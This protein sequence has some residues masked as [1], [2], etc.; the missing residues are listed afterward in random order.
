MNIVNKLTLRQL[1]MNKKRTL[2]T[3]IGTIISA[4]MIT[5]VATLS[6]S[7]MD[8][9]Q[10]D[11]IQSDG[12]W[13]AKY[14]EVTAKQ[15]STIRKDKQVKTVILS[16]DL[17][18]SYL[19][20]SR[21]N[22]KPYLSVLEYNKAGYENFPI[23]LT[24]G[25]L[26][27]NP[28]ELVI[29]QAVIDNAGVDLKLGDTLTL[30]LGL[31]T[32][33]LKNWDGQKLTQ[34]FPL[35]REGDESAEYLSEQ[36]ERSYT[37]VGIIAAP[38]WE[39]SW[40]PGY[41]ALSYMDEAS[42]ASEQ[43]F[44]VSVIYKKVT[45]KLFDH[46]VQVLPKAK[47]EFNNNL[48]RYYGVVKDDSVRNM[49]FIL[50]SIIIGIIVIGSVSLIYNAFA[51][52]VSERSR[53]LGMLSS[54]GA[55]RRQKRNSVFFE[56]AVIGSIS[57]PLGI[58]FGYIGLGITYLFINPIITQALYVN[59]GFRLRV[60]PSVLLVSVLVSSVTILISTYIPARRASRI[61]AI[62][63]IRQTADVRISRRQVRTLPI[64]RKLFGMEGDLGLKNLKRNKKRYQATIVSLIISMMLFLVVTDFT[65]SIKKSLLMT[66]DGINFDLWAN[67]EVEEQEKESVVKSITELEHITDY[68]RIDTLEARLM[69]KEENTADFLKA[70][71]QV[72][73]DDGTYPYQVYLNVLE[74]AALKTYAEDIG[75]D[76]KKLTD[77]SQCAAIVVDTVNYKDYN[78]DKY[79]KT[80]ALHTKLGETMDLTIPDPDTFDDIGQLQVK[81][82]VLTERL[83]M[84]IASSGKNSAV[85][86]I[87]SK[88]VFDY[89]LQDQKEAKTMIKTQVF[90]NSDQPN[91]LQEELETI[92]NEVGPSKL[93]IQNLYV[94]R[95]RE[96]QMA[97]LVGIFTY[98]FLIL[99]TAICVANIINT[100]STSIAL[101]KREFAMLKSVGITPKGFRKMLNYESIFYGLKAL[102]Y[103][104]PI[105]IGVMYLIHKAL[106]M[107][108]EF[109]FTVPL[110]SLITVVVAVF[111]IV[112]TAMLY[113]GSKV[114]KENIIDALKQEII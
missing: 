90:L 93:E 4:A 68:S 43:N 94:Y 37:I 70:T 84:G 77:P 66:Q 31:R 42:A 15:L 13:H 10:R 24:G 72:P 106:M 98:A 104:L 65:D 21:N 2:V 38:T 34:L 41:T 100:I 28:K 75:V 105:S 55:T 102:L 79:V 71:L 62:D 88:E 46:A 32:S 111:A 7:F 56:G 89:L 23:E 9:M 16:K 27:A 1:R 80:K 64:T 45:N 26:P 108:F 107:N 39:Y 110:T 25:R 59:V 20:G 8:L 44:D 67:L 3:I 22:N 74:D 81:V 33:T 85:N 30:K 35:Q 103:G 52:S 96:Q 87:L 86:L 58:L 113:S 91:K 95:Q 50:S 114:R 51:I 78:T 92:Q 63:A 18:Y 17:G 48:L 61:S 99:I 76:Y 83:P 57:I 109:P 53:Y 47:I 73:S 60:Y 14:L 5:A 82:T 19:N 49:L 69:V 101:R 29:S 40:A 12:E 36:E 112:G 6:L 11:T 54:V 97:L